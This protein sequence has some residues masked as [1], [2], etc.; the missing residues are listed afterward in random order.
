VRASELVRTK[1]G[2]KANPSRP[3]RAS[4]IAMPATPRFFRVSLKLTSTSAS[5]PLTLAS[6]SAARPRDRVPPSH[7]SAQVRRFGQEPDQ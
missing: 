5:I 7:P 4:T 3:L 1:S 6:P 2:L